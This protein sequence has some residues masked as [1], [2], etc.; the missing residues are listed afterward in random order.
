VAAGASAGENEGHLVAR[1]FPASLAIAGAWGYIGRKFVGAAQSL[2]LPT[3]VYDPGPAPD[4]LDL[5]GVTRIDAEDDFYRQRADLFHLALHPE[6]RQTGLNA[7]LRRGCHEPMLIL[8]EKPMAPPHCPQLCRETVAAV[9][10]SGAILLYDFPELFDP[11]TRRIEEFLAGFRVVTI[12]SIDVQRSKD[13]EDPTNPR[14]RKRMVTIQ[15]QESVHCLAFVLHVLATVRG[16]VA[17]ALSDGL[18][19]V[20]SAAPYDPPNPEAYP[21]PVDGRCEYRLQWGATTVTGL[22]DFKRGAPW[23]KRRV[24]RG[25]G[26]GQPFVID[27]EVLE[28]HKRLEINGRSQDDVVATN[29]YAEVIRTFGRW[30]Q[31]VPREA[32]MQGCYPNPRFAQVTYQLSSLLWQASHERRPVRLG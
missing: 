1:E 7:L 26:D 9:E 22:T 24:I 15:Y 23:T 13:R 32:L 28:G 31:R 30:T 16:G 3:L 29:S 20:A 14:N 21:Q 18:T 10:Q 4:D 17:A 25:H 11:I 27:A 2:G 8:C 12:D 5:R 19:A 6:H